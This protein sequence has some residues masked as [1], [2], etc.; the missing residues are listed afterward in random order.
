LG[1]SET[2]LCVQVLPASSDWDICTVHC[3]VDGAA[4]GLLR[5]AA[6]TTVG[7]S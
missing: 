4:A 7:V 1:W 6:A 3:A 2:G 5:L